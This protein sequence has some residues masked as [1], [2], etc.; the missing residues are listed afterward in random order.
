MPDLW[1]SGPALPPPGGP[2]SS[3][4]DRPDPGAQVRSSSGDVHHIDGTTYRAGTVREGE[5]PF[6]FEQV[7]R[8]LDGKLAGLYGADAVPAVRAALRDAV[9]AEGPGAYDRFGADPGAFGEVRGDAAGAAALGRDLGAVEALRVHGVAHGHLVPVGPAAEPATERTLTRETGPGWLTTPD[10]EIARDTREALMER[11]ADLVDDVG[12][13]RA[14]AEQKLALVNRSI[15]TLDLIGARQDL[16]FTFVNA[17][18]GSG[19]GITGV[20]P[21]PSDDGRPV[22]E[23][24]TAGDRGT[25]V[26]ANRVHELYHAGE[27]ARGR[28]FVRANARGELEGA[29]VGFHDGDEEVAAYRTQYAFNPRSLLRSDYDSRVPGFDRVPGNLADVNRSYVEGLKGQ[30]GRPAYRNLQWAP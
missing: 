6:P 28:V 29:A 5:T 21:D 12:R 26:A 13:G 16:A 8:G 14:G 30:D 22:V 25:D 4:L 15:E 7:D 17:E 10:A 20:R 23:I 27:Y 11:R 18:A 19:W 3:T 9:V 24:M 1:N 2:E